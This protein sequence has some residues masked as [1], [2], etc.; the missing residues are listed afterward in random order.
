[1]ALSFVEHRAGTVYATRAERHRRR[2]A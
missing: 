2:E 1:M